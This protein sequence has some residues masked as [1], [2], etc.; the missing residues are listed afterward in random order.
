MKSFTSSVC[1]KARSST[2]S[3][4]IKNYAL[5]VKL[6]ALPPLAYFGFIA[7]CIALLNTLN[8]AEVDVGRESGYFPPASIECLYAHKCTFMFVCAGK[9]K[10][11]YRWS[12]GDRPKS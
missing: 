3:Q 7:L 5:A 2:L 4:S 12:A 6:N 1:A 8:D 9:H 11:I 10:F